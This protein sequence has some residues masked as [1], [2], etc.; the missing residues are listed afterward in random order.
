V[1]RDSFYVGAVQ[2]VHARLLIEHNRLRDDA[3]TTGRDLVRREDALVEEYVKDKYGEGT[4][5]NK[6]VRLDYLG[7]QAGQEAGANI[8]LSERERLF[9]GQREL[10]A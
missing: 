2:R 5:D 4:I 8:E 7:V 3:G 10:G 1:W 6:D 9:Q